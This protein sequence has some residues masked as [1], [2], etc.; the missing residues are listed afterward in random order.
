M[1]LKEWRTKKAISIE[2]LAEKADVSPV[3]IHNIEHGNPSRHSTKRK[4]AKALGLKP[5]EIDF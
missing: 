5:E 3:T 2:E 4:I 1:N